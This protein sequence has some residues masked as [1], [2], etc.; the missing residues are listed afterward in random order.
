MYERGVTNSMQYQTTGIR[1]LD[2][3]LYTKSVLPK[4]PIPEQLK[5]ASILTKVDDTIQAVK[6]SIEKVERL[7]KSLMQNLLT[8]KLKPDGT[9]RT[10]D[11]FKDIDKYGWV[12]VDW[13][14]GKLGDIAEI[15]AGQSP[16]G[17]TYNENGGGIPMLNGPTE[18]TDRYPVPVQWTTKPTKLCKVGDILF[19]VRGSSTGRM[20]IAD[21]E[22]CIGRGIAAIREI[23][24][25]SNIDYIF[26]LLIIIANKILAEAKG[27]GSTF[28][29]VNRTELLKKRIIY[30]NESTQKLIAEKINSVDKI[31]IT[32]QQKIQKLE[33]L[34]KSLMQNLLTGKV[35]VKV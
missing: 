26:Y 18:F 5:I 17:E 10:D 9:W 19:T 3:K 25:K 30:P 27:A 34:K 33:R 16:I 21:Q 13:D 22:Y 1:N 31:V 15:I 24:D 2:F 4:P 32:K 23:E 14:Y 8:G 29:N 7:K 12:P 11:E 6:N 35:R 20:N 28:P